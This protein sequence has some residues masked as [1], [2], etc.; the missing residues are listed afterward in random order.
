ML[1]ME[2]FWNLIYMFA[3]GLLM[4]GYFGYEQGHKKALKKV[5][6]FYSRRNDF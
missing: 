4:G 3:V 2:L 5:K 6:R 1:D